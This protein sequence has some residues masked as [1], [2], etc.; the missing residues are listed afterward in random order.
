MDV[1]IFVIALIINLV[2][3]SIL[4][5]IACVRASEWLFNQNYQNAPQTSA[6]EAQERATSYGSV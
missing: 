6:D 5:I 4:F 3:L 2:L 1:E